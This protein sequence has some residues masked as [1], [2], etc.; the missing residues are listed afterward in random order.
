MFLLLSILLLVYYSS[1]IDETYLLW[2]IFV[3]FI[4]YRLCQILLNC[5][6]RNNI[7]P[8][9]KYINYFNTKPNKNVNKN[10]N[11]SSESELWSEESSVSSI[12]SE[13]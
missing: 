11:E 13:N 9:F 2:V 10:T 6:R 7:N 4:L 1:S 3:I 8:N 5:M 12:N